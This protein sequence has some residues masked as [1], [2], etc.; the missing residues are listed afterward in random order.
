MESKII[1]DILMNA[2]KSSNV[3][4]IGYDDLTQ[5]LQVNFKNGS[6]YQY[7]EIP[8]DLYKAFRGAPSIGNFIAKHIKGKYLTV[9]IEE[10][11]IENSEKTACN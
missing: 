9:K 6:K 7:Y 5:T 8:A 4:Q 1:S 10:I 11:K 3:E 2:V